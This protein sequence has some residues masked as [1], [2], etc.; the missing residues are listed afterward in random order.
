MIP[1]QNVLK[2]YKRSLHITYICNPCYN[3]Q[4]LIYLYK[5]TSTYIQTLL[6]LAFHTSC[7]FQRAILTHYLHPTYP[8]T[9]F[10]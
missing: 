9:D 10:G 4:V 8:T 5:D 2:V 1:K 6:P 7:A 3:L